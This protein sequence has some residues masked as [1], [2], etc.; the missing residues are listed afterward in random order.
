VEEWPLALEAKLLPL[1]FLCQYF[2]SVFFLLL[3]IH[4][5]IYYWD[6]SPLL[7]PSD[8]QCC[9]YCFCGCCTHNMG[10]LKSKK[11]KTLQNIVCS[12]PQAVSTETCNY[13]RI[14]W[15]IH[16]LNPGNLK[17]RPRHAPKNISS[18]RAKC[19]FSLIF[20]LPTNCIQFILLVANQKSP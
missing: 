19:I 1:Y 12:W 17:P 20:M 8:C 2:L 14:L 4:C 15:I 11:K 5:I 13:V 3:L 16:A 9:I 7:I 18:P 10:Q 6:F